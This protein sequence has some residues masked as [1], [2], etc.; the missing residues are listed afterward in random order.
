[1]ISDFLSPQMF[2]SFL[3]GIQFGQ[4]VYWNDSHIS[5]SYYEVIL[6][7][8]YELRAEAVPELPP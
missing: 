8:V 2:P 4:I 7:L 3:R 6:L 1:M 5:L